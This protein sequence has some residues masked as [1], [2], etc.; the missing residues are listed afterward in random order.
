MSTGGGGGGGTNTTIQKSDPPEWLKPFQTEIG[1]AASS[2][3]N[4]R[5]LS[6]FPGQTFAGLSPETQAALNMQTQRALAGSPVTSA[7]QTELTNTLSGQ[8]LD[9]A[10]NPAFQ[11]ASQQIAGQIAGQ[12]EGAGRY[13]SGAM[14][15]QQR[16]ALTD[17]AAKTYGDERQRQVQSMLF[18]PQMAQQDYFDAAKLAEVGGVR[19]DFTQ[20]GINEAIERFNF[21][22]MEPWQ[23]L[24]LYSGTL[25][26][27]PGMGMTTTGTNDQRRSLGAG[28]A[29]GALTSLGGLG[30][31]GYS[32]L[33]DIR[34]KED[35][36]RV[37]ETD[38][39][40]GVYTYRY[41]GSPVTQMGVMAQEVEQVR[42]EA[43]TQVGGLKAVNYGLLGV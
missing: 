18:A 3:Y 42:P 38:E 22:Q 36:K 20:Q 26:G 14:A 35:I 16:E 17:L 9:P 33:S 12:F 7:A 41:K 28:D 8:Y 43:V 30:L 11:K 13:G 4:T 34:A 39:G 23:R 6:M 21:N 37:G 31:L 2:L 25:Q 24:Q 1:S 5:P 40:L 15:N 32:I 29:F 27:I 19:E 10:T